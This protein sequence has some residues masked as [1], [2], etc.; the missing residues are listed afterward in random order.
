[1]IDQSKRDREVQQI[2]ESDF[3]Q[4]LQGKVRDMRS[5]FKKED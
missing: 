2:V 5:R 4:E 3:F 1:M